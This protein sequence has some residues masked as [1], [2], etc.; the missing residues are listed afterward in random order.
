MFIGYDELP[1]H[2]HTS[3]LHSHYKHT[4]IL[5]VY[6]YSLEVCIYMYVYS[7]V[8]GDDDSIYVADSHNHCIRRIHNDQVITISGQPRVSGHLDGG[9]SLSTFGYPSDLAV[10]I[11]ACLFSLS[12]FLLYIY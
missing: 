6:M 2:T 10:S 7:L 3:K 8:L 12:L 9:P 5:H 4:S 1:L 11:H